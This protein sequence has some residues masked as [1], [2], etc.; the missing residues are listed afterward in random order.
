MSAQ[1]LP[2]AP[3]RCWQ[4]W[5]RPQEVA[6]WIKQLHL[7]YVREFVRD[8]VHDHDN[9]Q[10]ATLSGAQETKSGEDELRLS[11]NTAEPVNR[12]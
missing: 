7:E 8:A 1:S 6:L 9:T 3:L 12:R 10:L 4:L 11:P 5:G 2:L